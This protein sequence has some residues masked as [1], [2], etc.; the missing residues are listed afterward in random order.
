MSKWRVKCISVDTLGLKESYTAVCTIND[1]K[2]VTIEYPPGSGFGV[3][4]IV[5]VPSEEY[6][7]LSMALSRAGEEDFFSFEVEKGDYQ[8]IVHKARDLVKSVGKVSLK[9]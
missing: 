8:G 5:R 2:L 6:D 1:S 9:W 4:K 3:I 7:E